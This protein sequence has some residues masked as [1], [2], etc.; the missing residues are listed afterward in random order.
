MR[1]REESWLLSCWLGG[2]GAAAPTLAIL[3]GWMSRALDD[4]IRSVN[5][6]EEKILREGRERE[7]GGR[8]K[9]IERQRESLENLGLSSSNDIRTSK[10]NKEK[11]AL[12]SHYVHLY[13][14]K[15]H[16]WQLLSSPQNEI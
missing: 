6:G 10:E 8:E 2:G 7:R 9:E 13:Q 11:K 1:G 5:P 3:Y 12:L 14:I 15:P 16:F 4:C